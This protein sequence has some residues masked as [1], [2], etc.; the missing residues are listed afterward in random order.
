M[1]FKAV[2]FGTLLMLLCLT[3]N[4]EAL[5]LDYPHN[6]DNGIKCYHCHSEDPYD[7]TDLWWDG[8]TGPDPDG[9]VYNWVCYTRC[10]AGDDS[11]HV[12]VDPNTLFRGPEKVTHSTTTTGSNSYS[13]TTECIAC[14]DPHF[15]EQ[16][17]WDATDP[18]FVATGTY[19][20]PAT[21]ALPTEDPEINPDGLGAPGI[22]ASVVRVVLDPG[23]IYDPA[24]E[25][26]VSKGGK[27]ADPITGLAWKER[28]VDHSRGLILVANTNAITTTYTY[29]IVKMTF[30]SGSTWDMMVKGNLTEAA[31]DVPF[32]VIFGNLLADRVKTTETYVDGKGVTRNVRRPVKFFSTKSVA[33]GAGGPAD[34]TPGS[35][36]PVGMC[37]VCHTMTSSYKSTVEETAHHDAGD[38]PCDECHQ[39][40]TGGEPIITHAP[41][42]IDIGAA[43]CAVVCHIGYGTDPDQA[44]IG[45]GLEVDCKTCHTDTAPYLNANTEIRVPYTSDGTLHA[46]VACTTCHNLTY[47]GVDYTDSLAHPD[48]TQEA[49][50]DTKHNAAIAPKALCVDA[51]HG[52]LTA[53]STGVAIVENSDAP[54]GGHAD[55]CSLCHLTV[56]PPVELTAGAVVA[57]TNLPATTDCGGC[58]TA[59]FDG[60]THDHSLSVVVNSSGTPNTVN[61]N[62]CHTAPA[63]NGPFVATGEPHN[64]GGCNTC[65]LLDGVSPDGSLRGSANGANI[66]GILADSAYECG[67]CHAAHFDG[68]SHTHGVAFNASLDVTTGGSACNVCHQD[69]NGLATSLD[70]WAGIVHEHDVYDGLQD[71]VNVCEVC[72][73]YATNGNR[74]GD[75]DTPLAATVATVITSGSNVTC[76][77]CHVKKNTESHGSH[78]DTEFAW[79]TA[80]RSSCGDDGRAIGACHADG[81][82][83]DVIVDIH[84][85][86]LDGNCALC[87]VDVTT[88]QYGRIVG[89]DGDATLASGRAAICTE[90]HTTLNHPKPF[91]HHANNGTV[92]YN[93]ATDCASRCHNTANSAAGDHTALV[94]NA[95]EIIDVQK[96]CNTCHT[97]TAGSAD[98][99][100]ISAVDDKVHDACTQCHEI[101]AT[102]KM[103]ELVAPSGSVSTMDN[104]DG[105]TA[106]NNG[107][108]PC[109]D[110]HTGYFESHIHHNVANQVAQNTTNSTFP[111]YLD[112]SWGTYQ[113]CSNNGCHNDSGLFL[114]SWSDI[115][116][117]H[118]RHDKDPAIPPGNTVKD[119]TGA[120]VNCH[121]HN[122]RFGTNED[123]F[124]IGASIANVV[125]AGIATNCV[126]CHF[127]KRAPDIHGLIYVNHMEINTTGQ[128][129]VYGT[130]IPMTDNSGCTTVCHPAGND[131]S[132]LPD[133]IL[134]L[135]NNPSCDICHTSQPNLL[136]TP[137]NFNQFQQSVT[138]DSNG[139]DCLECHQDAI[140]LTLVGGILYHG[141]TATHAQTQSRHNRMN[142]PATPGYSDSTSGYYC[143]D[144]HAEMTPAMGDVLT[145]HMPGFVDQ[146]DCMVCH[147]PSVYDIAIAD[148]P[149]LTVVFNGKQGGGNLPQPCEKCHTGKGAYRLHGMTGDSGLDGVA[150]E[151]NNLS[152]SGAVDCSSCHTMGTEIDRLT[153]HVDGCA[154]LS[155]HNPTEDPDPQGGSASAVIDAGLPLSNDG[156]P[157]GSNLPQTCDK[158]HVN[159]NSYLMHG[160]SNLTVAGAHEFL[161]GSST[162]SPGSA[163]DCETCH[164]A[165]TPETRMGLH[166]D[167]DMCHTALDPAA[168]QISQGMAGVNV[169][170][171]SCHTGAGVH[172]MHEMTEVLV[173]PAHEKISTTN[174]GFAGDDHCGNC[175]AMGTYYDILHIHSTPVKTAHTGDCLTCHTAPDD[176]DGGSAATSISNGTSV[177]A[178]GGGLVQTCASC[179]VTL[180]SYSLHSLTVSGIAPVHEYLTLPSGATSNCASG[181]GACHVIT[182]VLDRIT[183]HTNATTSCVDCHSWNDTMNTAIATGFNGIPANVGCEKCHDGAAGSP[184]ANPPNIAGDWYLHLDPDHTPTGYNVVLPYTPASPTRQKCMECHNEANIIDA[185]QPGVGVHDMNDNADAKYS[186]K[187]CHAA[188]SALIGSALG[189][190]GGGD[191]VICHTGGFDSHL[192]RINSHADTSYNTTIVPLDQTTSAVPCGDCHNGLNADGDGIP[193]N[194]WA[195]IR[196]EHTTIDGA[197]SYNDCS[198]CHD[199]FDN[200]NRS[201]AAGTPLL[202]D[203]NAA[204]SLDATVYCKNCHEPK[205]VEF[206]GGHDS[207]HWDWTANSVKT[208]GAAGCHDYSAAGNPDVVGSVHNGP[209]AQIEYGGNS[210]RNCHNQDPLGVGQDGNTGG[211]GDHLRGTAEI[212]T[213]GGPVDPV[214]HTE[215]CIVCHSGGNAFDSHL[216]DHS[217]ELATDPV[218][219]TLDNTLRSQ[220][221][222]RCHTNTGGAAKAFI[223]GSTH[224]QGATGCASCHA[225]P[226][227]DAL[228][229]DGTRISVAANSPTGNFVAGGPADDCD[230]CHG[231]GAYFDSHLVRGAAGSHAIT[232]DPLTDISQDGS[233]GS[234]CGDAGCHLAD[235]DG[236][237]GPLSS[238]QDI[239]AEHNNSCVI[240]HD[241]NDSAGGT[242]PL[243]DNYNAIDTLASSKCV[244]CHVPK[245]FNVSPSTSTHGG[246]AA[247]DFA[248]SASCGTWDCHNSAD[249]PD[250]VE[251]VHGISNNDTKTD[252]A[253]ANSQFTNPLYGATG[254]TCL[255]CHTV[256]GGGDGTTLGSVPSVGTY[257]GFVGTS[258]L[259]PGAADHLETCEDC[260]GTNIPIIHHYRNPDKVNADNPGLRQGDP[261]WTS[262]V[263]SGNCYK[264]HNDNNFRVGVAPTNYT[265]PQIDVWEELGPARSEVLH[266]S[267]NVDSNRPGVTPCAFCHMINTLTEFKIKKYNLSLTMAA[268]AAHSDSP[269]P[270]EGNYTHLIPNYGT[271]IAIKNSGN[272]LHCHGQYDNRPANYPVTGTPGN[273]TFRSEGRPVKPRH[274]YT[275]DM[276]AMDESRAAQIPRLRVA[277]HPGHMK[278]QLM[279]TQT[280]PTATNVPGAGLKVND[281]MNDGKGNEKLYNVAP[282]DATKNGAV[283]NFYGQAPKD[284]G[285][286]A[287]HADMTNFWATW[288]VGGTMDTDETNFP[289]FAGIAAGSKIR[290]Y[291]GMLFVP[292]ATQSVL[293]TINDNDGPHEVPLNP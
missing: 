290:D 224:T 170:C 90:C 40:V 139:V 257:N 73:N 217:A 102:T 288:G 74:S 114:A 100:P 282:Y 263:Q 70:T 281:R 7:G 77:D 192:Q 37:Q 196:A 99:V 199:Y 163:E 289:G 178:G 180:N 168:T 127:A 28:G 10:H 223:G 25:D 176:I 5:R 269:N 272:C 206:H 234:G 156:Y 152:T 67:E 133:P 92:L 174:S 284:I 154:S 242:P 136:T 184:V 32:G 55:N 255:N 123:K 226:L 165:G 160:M 219:S 292:V 116:Y 21:E 42:F 190:T 256:A 81:T 23:P 204:I 62:G 248:W 94:A 213:N 126:D 221:C 208:C 275:V 232:Y 89:I 222:D 138:L 60:H 266:G 27:G 131:L 287:I 134:G 43:V 96:A 169:Y 44:H 233:A 230:D 145:R 80:T 239:L 252:N 85:D 164:A 103:V 3:G 267:S 1:K 11:S 78:I 236:I 104:I 159:Q 286:S 51:C 149:S 203:V 31:L 48:A 2:V 8:Y 260:H 193:L 185:G 227:S 279:A 198:M 16:I 171:E 162:L 84:G 246:H 54:V 293:Y 229:P 52:T 53:L 9:S 93:P 57:Q 15:Q 97:A 98:N 41:T 117:E 65:H 177:T 191:C 34:L 115:Q 86:G 195:D 120:C 220:D 182:T 278:Y 12:K 251:D 237:N 228:G 19:S 106:T 153:L 47:G 225:L 231:A 254:A 24:T 101:N 271:N 166:L 270:F 45:A 264:C 265:Q 211:V 175:H 141:V 259:N 150:T 118:D 188:D 119:G 22:G 167:C 258:Q 189:K 215:E 161:L 79:T 261:T 26:W 64:P 113:P 183:I 130:F 105:T 247:T 200:G 14:H 125:A 194:S 36:E 20:G 95:P 111:N 250:V 283:A 68:H 121:Y 135:H 146:N 128:E 179:H 66:S 207:T 268:D 137:V 155:C 108:G 18:I 75:P 112:E 186:C 91:I 244:T 71:R 202:S 61:C 235:P 46:A 148:E 35:T 253:P 216:H 158:C 122:S 143:L 187:I 30:V 58:H 209:W 218:D 172:T 212:T 129:G 280:T 29:E 205:Y 243:A 33:G 132:G 50:K 109:T 181:A 274:G 144:C 88:N 69:Y 72:H 140:D 82:N 245:D 173:A 197:G 291:R 17:R 210:C 107:G 262:R 124:G 157:N 276:I 277:M 240:C 201:G 142:D 110:C 285:K 6:V 38:R 83:T 151:H 59:Y 249:N 49:N 273:F 13:F 87:H 39:M 238:W 214:I 4:G 63:G 76:R 147:K 241:Y 56:T